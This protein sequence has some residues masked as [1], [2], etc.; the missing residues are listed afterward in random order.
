MPN[1]QLLSLHSPGFCCWWF[2]HSLK[3]FSNWII[4]NFS[5]DS[6]NLFYINTST[7]IIDKIS[8]LD[9]MFLQFVCCTYSTMFYT[10]VHEPLPIELWTFMPCFEFLFIHLCI[11]RFVGFLKLG[12]SF[13]FIVMSDGWRW[14]CAIDWV[15]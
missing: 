1:T 11:L 8:F 2:I 6:N 10:C 15:H 13:G 9:F 4:Y 7:L 3:L 14:W 5:G 12:C